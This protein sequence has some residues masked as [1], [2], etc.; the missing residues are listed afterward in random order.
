MRSIAILFLSLFITAT[1]E[2]KTLVIADIDD[3]LRVTNRVYASYTEQLENILNLDMPFSGMKEL[4]D[5]FHSQNAKIYY[6]TAAV[7]P[8]DKI[9]EAFL[10][11]NAF[12]QSYRFIYKEWW[13]ETESYKVN[14]IRRLINK[15]KPDI[16]ILIGDNG[17]KDPAAYSRIQEMY[18]QAHVFIHYLYK[19]GTSVPVPQNQIAYITTAE[20]AA[21]LEHHG[22]VSP[23]LSTYVMDVVWRDLNASLPAQQLVLPVWS[24]VDQSD[25]AS[26]FAFPFVVSDSSH[27]YLELIMSDLFIRVQ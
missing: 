26:L 21:H 5:V 14:E 19:Y 18:P 27:Q 12:P 23:E 11:H 9:S 2:A 22:I 16:I 1:V 4:M 8:L 25:V 15:E 10:E 20:V 3:T 6:L 17:E 24:D 7:E 13:Q